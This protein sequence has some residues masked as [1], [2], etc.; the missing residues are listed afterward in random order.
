VGAVERRG[1]GDPAEHEQ[2]AER[3][4]RSGLRARAAGVGAGGAASGASASG[5]VG[6]ELARIELLRSIF[7]SSS[8]KLLLGI[9]DDAAVLA[10]VADPLV[11]TVDAAVE[12]SHFRRDLL[13]LE[14]IGYRSTMAAASDLAAMGAEPIALL[15]ALVLPADLTDGD[16]QRLAEGQRAAASAIGA[17]IAGGNLARGSELS[18]TTTVLGSTPRPLRRSGARPGDALWLAGPVGLAAAGLL[19]LERRTPAKSQSAEAA[20]TSWRQPTARIAAGRDARAVA[21]AAIDISDGL[22][23]DAGHIARS[24]GVRVVL[25]PAAFVSPVLI[26]VAAELEVDPLD[27]ALS[28]GE[29]YAILAAAPMGEDLPDFIRVGRCDAQEPGGTAVVLLAEDGS[30]RSI[31]ERGFD[32]FARSR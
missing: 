5:G 32:H 13:P 22:L 26:E 14:D 6:S 17:P 16:L 21:T 11:W 15:A 24:S 23:R 7:A 18:I 1:Q 30:L 3:A 29:D 4:R 19:L 9:G 27:L 10:A 8:D 25:D 31:E 12:G 20:V 2:R 28:G